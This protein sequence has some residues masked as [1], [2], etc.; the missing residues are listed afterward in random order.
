MNK[1][2]YEI[3]MILTIIEDSSDEFDVGFIQITPSFCV[4][5]N[6]LS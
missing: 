3:M 6:S 5:E 4:S 1:Q 2:M